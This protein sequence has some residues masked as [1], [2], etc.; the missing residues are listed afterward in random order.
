M[1]GRY[2]QKLA[3]KLATYGFHVRPEDIISVKGHHDSPRWKT[4]GTV[5]QH[6]SLP[7]GT[8]IF[9]YSYEMMLH[10]IDQQHEFMFV[11]EQ[12]SLTRFKVCTNQRAIP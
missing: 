12:G 11:R 3:D 10:C 8:T 2:R 7:R 5:I 1:A 4:K 9:L 6:H